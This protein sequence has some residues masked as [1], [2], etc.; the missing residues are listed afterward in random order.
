MRWDVHAPDDL[1]S[2]CLRSMS[3]LR[4]VID[5]P[6]RL[7]LHGIRASCPAWSPVISSEFRPR[8][9]D[10][11]NGK[12]HGRLVRI[13]IQYR[14]RSIRGFHSAIVLDKFSPVRLD[15]FCDAYLLDD[16]SLSRQI[17]NPTGP[18]YPAHSIH[19]A[20]SAYHFSS[21]SVDI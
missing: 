15:R 4:T 16:G 5:N 21:S 11:R 13:R 10:A 17:G 6:L 1:F 8:H 14:F 2:H 20:S 3:K 19:P 7:Y 18:L 12:P 9:P